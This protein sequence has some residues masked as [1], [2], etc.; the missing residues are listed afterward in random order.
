MDR[1]FPLASRSPRGGRSSAVLRLTIL[2]LMILTAVPS[3]TV[4]QEIRKEGDPKRILTPIISPPSQL[5]GGIASAAAGIAKLLFYL[6]L[7][8]AAVLLIAALVGGRSITR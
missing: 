3:A 6:F 2:L 5:L 7:A 8:V 1:R 4:A